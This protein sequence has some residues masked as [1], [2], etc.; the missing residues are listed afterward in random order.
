MGDQTDYIAQLMNS[1]S[2]AQLIDIDLALAPESA[3]TR[4][5]TSIVQGAIGS[6]V[7]ENGGMER[8]V[9]GKLHGAVEEKISENMN[10]I[11]KLVLPEVQDE[12][13]VYVRQLITTEI[14]KRVKPRTDED[15]LRSRVRKF[16]LLSGV[17]GGI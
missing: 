5:I 15:A 14:E 2:V 12:I 6:F 3:L 1:D 17:D 4:S 9:L 7:S 11:V 13:D 10:S 8:M 16:T